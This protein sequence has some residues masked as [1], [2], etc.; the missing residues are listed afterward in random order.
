M[1]PEENFSRLYPIILKMSEEKV[2]FV[3]KEYAH[4]FVKVFPYFS[5]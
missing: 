3:K 2:D 4:N 5:Q 1:T